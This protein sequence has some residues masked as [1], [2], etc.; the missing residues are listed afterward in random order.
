MKRIGLAVCLMASGLLV[1]AQGT[2][3]A[4]I[5]FEW[6]ESTLSPHVSFHN[7]TGPVL[8]DDFVPALGGSVVQVDWWGSAP[9]QALSPDQWEITFHADAGG[10]PAFPVMSQHFVASG[11]VDPDGDGVF[12][13]S[14][15]WNPLDAFINAGS[16]YWFS[17]AN[18]SG[19]GWTWANP[20]PPA[21]TV[22]FENFDAVVSVGGTPSVVAG[23]HDGPWSAI[24]DQDF[25]F[26]IWVD[27]IQDP[28]PEPSTLLL[29]GTGL[30]GLAGYA[31]RRK[32]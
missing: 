13:Y 18:A 27:D 19:N 28:V 8:A 5:A 10:V 2:G 25:A 6:T 3:A 32:S 11:G 15:A 23:P 29:L 20:L 16:Q 1:T 14:A 7:T 21:P 31:R 26:R 17:V 22:G 9:Q 4:L 24:A 12:F 30:V